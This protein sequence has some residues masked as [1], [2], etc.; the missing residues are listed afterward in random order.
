M[1]G[2]TW[3]DSDGDCYSKPAQTVVV[4]NGA[5]ELAEAQVTPEELPVES[6]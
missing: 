2:K 3:F 4:R 1:T 6:E 5:F